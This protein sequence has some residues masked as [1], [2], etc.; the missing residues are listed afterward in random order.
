MA[1]VR[2]A[3]TPTRES[4]RN[5]TDLGGGRRVTSTELITALLAKGCL[6]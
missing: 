5:E 2:R 3:S 4:E 1:P 6:R